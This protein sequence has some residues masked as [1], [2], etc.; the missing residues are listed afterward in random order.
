MALLPQAT[1]DPQTTELPDI[2]VPQTTDV[3]HTTEEPQTTELLDTDEFP[4]E[5]VI[6]P[7]E[8]VVGTIGE[9][10]CP[11]RARRQVVVVQRRLQVERTRSDGE[12]VVVA[13]KVCR[14]DAELSDRRKSENSCTPFSSS[15]LSP[16]PE[17]S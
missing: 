1:D 7:L 10:R 6:V 3:P 14:V 12:Q 5:S 17:L 9:S 15:A 2:F 8:A 4:Y 16:G 11:H 13:G